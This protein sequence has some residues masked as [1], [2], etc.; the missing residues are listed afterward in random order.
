[1]NLGSLCQDILRVFKHFQALKDASVCLVEVSPLLS[2]IQARKLC[3][4]TVLSKNEDDPVYRE[5]TSVAHK[6]PIKWYRDLKNVPNIFTLLIAHEFFD[7]LPIHKFRKTAS[8]Y[9]EVLIDIDKGKDMCFRYVL[10]NHETPALKLFLKENEKRDEFEV[11][12]Q[13]LVIVKDIATRLEQDG[14][15]ALLADYGHVGDG[16]DTF[17]AYR[18]HKQHD[19][20]MEPG[21]ADLTADVDFGMLKNV[22]I[23]SY[24]FVLILI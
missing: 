15:L 17:R 18:K 9:R 19:P 14:G 23:L 12:P 20:L 13:S 5:G 21:T 6:I 10:A 16:T 11:S 7:A 8:G 22:R 24:M 3:V 1:M 2:D 4:Q